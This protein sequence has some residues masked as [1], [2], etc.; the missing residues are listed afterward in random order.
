[1]TPLKTLLVFVAILIGIIV[2]L[3]AGFFA[4]ASGDTP[5]AALGR[6]GVAFVGAVTLTLL[7]IGSL[8]LL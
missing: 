6:G 7:I 4:R 5:H 1:M 8:G 2:A 3:I